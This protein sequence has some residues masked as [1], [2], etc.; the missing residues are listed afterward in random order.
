MS[1]EIKM[2]KLADFRKKMNETAPAKERLASLFDESSFVELDAFATAADGQACGVVTG[3]GYVDGNPVYAFSQDITAESGAVTAAHAKKIKKIYDLAAKTGSPVV[4]IYDSNGAKLTEGMDALGAYGEIMLAVNNLSGV[5]PQISLVLGTCAGNMAMIACSADV[6]IMSE[7]AEF[8]L[9][10]PF[11]AVANGEDAALA[12]TAKAA[13]ASGAVHLVAAD[14]AAAIESA[15]KVI[16]ML[17]SNNLSIA[18]IFDFA[19]NEVAVTANSSAKEVINA[20]ADV[21]SLVELQPG[22]GACMVTAL[23]TIAGNPVG[24]VAT[25]KSTP[26][27]AAGANK[28]A[29]FVRFC[30]AFNL[31]I[32][33][34]VDTKGFEVSL[35]TELAGSIRE[36]AKLAHAYA[37]ATTAKV[38]VVTGEAYGPAYTML[39]GKSSNADV[40][41]AWAGASISALKPETSVELLWHEKLAGAKNLS[42]ARAELVEEYKNTLA[43]PFEAAKDGYLDNVILPEETRNTVI[44]ALDMLAGKRVSKLPKKHGNMPL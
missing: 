17:P 12:G 25:D 5:V 11:T 19:A 4:G 38:S 27:C 41:V 44:C 10:A 26:I 13:E 37:E 18:P 14:D 39:A 6:V 43:S 31:P 42:T 33:T 1:S 40:A 9:T 35:A 15:R 22:F 20:V 2:Q 7:K 8:F 3:Y 23:A 29:R 21:D 28:A 34:F 24:V 32:V 36:M 30:D 16:G